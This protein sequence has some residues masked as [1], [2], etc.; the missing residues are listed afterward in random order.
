[1]IF[2]QS[3]WVTAKFEPRDLWVGVYWQKWMSRPALFE[4]HSDTISTMGEPGRVEIFI[5]VLPMLPIVIGLA[6][7]FQY[8][9]KRCHG[10]PDDLHHG[11]S[12]V[13]GHAYER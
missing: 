5:C 12:W 6:W 8:R 13:T 1:M 2:G 10:G 3:S 7:P 11:K 9:C 4:R